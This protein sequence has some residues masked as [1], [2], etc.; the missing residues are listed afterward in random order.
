[1]NRDTYVTLSFVA[2][3]LVVV[4]FVVL[5]V[6]RIFLGYGTAKYLSAPFGLVAFVLV[7][8]LF[9]DGVRT[10]VLGTRDE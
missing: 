10:T 7:V 2:F 3:G 4:S 8:V 9:L 6:S 5:G 1:M